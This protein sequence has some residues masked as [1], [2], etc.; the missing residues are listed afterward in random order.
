MSVATEKPGQPVVVVAEHHP[1]R[2]HGA[3]L[4]AD[5]VG[6]RALDRLAVDV[7]PTGGGEDRD[8]GARAPSRMPDPVA[9]R[10]L[11]QQRCPRASRTGRAARRRRPRSLCP[12]SDASRCST[13]SGVE[14][15]ASGSGCSSRI[16]SCC[17]CH[18]TPRSPRHTS[19]RLRHLRRATRRSSAGS[20]STE[21][22]HVVAE[23][24][25]LAAGD[26]DHPVDRHAGC[27]HHPHRLVAADQRGAG[28]GHDALGAVEVVEVG[29]A[30]DDPVALVDVVGGQPGAGGVRRA[31]DVGVEE[32]GQ[33]ARCAGGTSRSRTSRAW[34]PCRSSPRPSAGGGPIV[35]AHGG[36]RHAER[37]G[38]PARLRF[39]AVS[40]GMRGDEGTMS[41][42][43]EEPAGGGMR[44]WGLVEDGGARAARGDL[45][46]PRRLGA[47]LRPVPRRPTPEHT[48]VTVFS[49]VPEHYPDPPSRWS[50]LGGFTAADDV[51]G[52]S[53]GRGPAGVAPARGD[54][55][56]ARL[57]GVDVHRATTPG[58]PRR[59]SRPCSGTCS[60]SSIP[61]WCWCRSA[62]PTPSTSWCTR[63]RCW[64]ANGVWRR[65]V[66]WV[67]YEDI[68]YNQIPGQ[69]AWRV[70]T[71]FRAAVWPTPVAMP[72]DPSPDAKRAAVAEYTSQVLALDADWSL[73]PRLDCAHARAVLAARRTA[74]PAGRP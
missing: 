74:R 72:V 31:V 42:Q 65:P 58:R 33:P 12:T 41:D 37:A 69:L 46:A 32:D 23:V 8:V 39:V 9:R 60:T 68:A 43:D 55:P 5:E 54:A 57:P 2:P 29:V 66:E 16:R 21:T 28:A 25:P 15:G 70:A 40:E 18:V 24:D 36:R 52:R 38:D 26:A 71:L 17:S 19:P 3:D 45:A 49:G 22:E 4:A 34:C 1:A 27:L 44:E 51:V 64:C 6:E 59:R 11:V 73:W 50:Q 56:V 30:D 20:G 47:Q 14:R 10:V 67:A 62:W 48:V 7:A 13:A 53:A 35:G 63:P 61:R